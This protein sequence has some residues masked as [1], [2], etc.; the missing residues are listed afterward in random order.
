[1][2][3]VDWDAAFMM[4]L[5]PILKRVSFVSLSI[6]VIG[7]GASC[8][9]RNITSAKQGFENENILRFDVNC[10]FTS[11]NPAAVQA[12]GSIQ[13]IPLLY[14]CLVVPGSK[15]GLQ[16]DLAVKWDY[17]P[18]RLT[19]TIHLNERARFHNHHPVTA[20]DVQYSIE[21]MLKDVNP[22][23]SASIARISAASDRVLIVELRAN[24]PE[25][26]QKLSGFAITPQSDG[27]KIDYYNGPVGSGPFR[28][29]Y[30]KGNKEVGLVANKEY[31]GDRPALDSVVFYYE[32]DKEKT[33]T[34]LLSGETDVAQEIS[35]V[36]YK[37][38]GHMRNRFHF[39][40]YTLP[41]YAI[42]LYNTSDPL[43]SDPRVRL[44]LTH[45][46]D[47]EYIVESILKGSGVVAVSPMGVD[48][49]YH[50]PQIRPIP[51]DPE[52]GLRLLEEAGWSY[53][54][55]RRHLA[56]NGKPF[57]F[58]IF[59]FEEYQIE[60]KVAQYIKLCLNELGIKVRLQAIPHNELVR[61]YRRNNEFQAVLTEFTGAYHRPDNLLELWTPYRGKKS[62]AGCFE[63]S[64]VT[65][66]LYQFFEEG[67]VENKA[68]LYEVEALLTSL[69]PG[70]FL[71]HKTAADVMSK[72]IKLPCPFSLTV[73]GISRLK[74]ASVAPGL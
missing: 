48:S 12:S 63:H 52:K 6:V 58:T 36:N 57:E 60:K 67:I 31:W 22:G 33:W 46:I 24:D 2:S 69:Q 45:A 14:S 4:S 71:F 73:G 11:L 8:E 27:S 19:W 3:L 9:G 16:P 65:R 30:R 21:A 7:L 40:E 15:G 64:E 51:Y 72:R 10:P 5:S 55:K 59:L 37:M 17:D 68:L 39:N 53:D 42:L 41:Y 62:R 50:D 32:V 20:Q 61:R 29:A 70:T 54:D 28:F 18:E 44:A 47:R 38:M 56:K 13:I 66:L 35:P 49:S 26:F 74:Y 23:L 25:F 43:L 1:M 34:R